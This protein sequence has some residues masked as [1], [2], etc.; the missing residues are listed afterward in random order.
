MANVCF[1]SYRLH[2]PKEELQFLCEKLNDWTKQNYIKNGYGRRWL[3]NVL[4]GCL[5]H[6][7]ACTGDAAEAEYRRRKELTRKGTAANEMAGS[8]PVDWPEDF[9]GNFIDDPYIENDELIFE[10][11]TAW[12]DKTEALE[13]V[14]KKLGLSVKCWYLSEEFANGV[15]CTND[16]TGAVFN[17]WYDFYV[18]GVLEAEDSNGEDPEYIESEQLNRETF[19][20]FC[21]EI[22]GR[23]IDRD[24][25]DKELDSIIG[26][27]ECYEWKNEDSYINIY[28]L[29]RAA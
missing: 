2:G 27:I 28:R 29:E 22:L 9:R 16:T 19:I 15:Y 26:E 11:E 8:E 3:G 21:E 10:T 17:E 7:G 1:T 6:T 23:Q 25:S 14:I 5:I 4:I 12:S 13:W 24:V 18:D 20:E